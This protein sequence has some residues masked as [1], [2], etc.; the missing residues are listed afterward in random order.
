LRRRCAED[1]G[2]N[3][4]TIDWER[5]SEPQIDQYDS[6]VILERVGPRFEQ[7]RFARHDDIRVFGDHVVCKPNTYWDAEEFPPAEATHPNVALAC[8]FIGRWPA[9]F[10]QCKH[11]LS[12]VLVSWW[13]KATSGTVGCSSGPGPSG[14]G[15]ICVTIFNPLG[16]A[17]GIVHELAHHKLRALG[18]QMEAAE[19]LIT[20]S[21][22]EL[23]HS[24]IRYDQLRPMS[25]VLHAEY[26]YMHVAQLDIYAARSP[27]NF[28]ERRAIASK[29]LAF[30]LPKLE[31]GRRVIKNNIRLDGSG[32][33]FIRGLLSWLDSV[34][35]NGYGILD[36]LEVSP[37]PFIHPLAVNT[38]EQTSS[39]R[40]Q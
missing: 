5:L 6:R 37:V 33:A 20:N 10:E 17:E 36:D 8:D 40:C 9:A 7:Q 22:A 12:E 29:T 21:S 30:Y 11:L 23:Y 25:A 39:E 35:R 27:T 18:I 13:S 32:N 19:H 24:P 26:S 3:Q 4:L 15:S 38:D 28:A 1:F 2:L 34:L 31:Y 16:A 14:F